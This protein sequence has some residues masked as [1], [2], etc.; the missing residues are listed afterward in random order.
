VVCIAAYSVRNK[1]SSE[2]LF[3]LVRCL[4]L[5]SG[6][7]DTLTITGHIV[8]YRW[9]A[10]NII[11]FV[12]TFFPCIPKENNRKKV[13]GGARDTSW[14]SVEVFA[15]HGVSFWRNVVF[16]LGKRKSWC[17]PYSCGPRVPGSPPLQ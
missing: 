6:G 17:G 14:F 16:Y 5:S 3:T 7:W 11:N 10:A 2:N 4:Y 15:Y 1:V 12:L 8:K 13:W 9:W